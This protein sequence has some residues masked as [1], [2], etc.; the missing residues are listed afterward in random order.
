MSL[1]WQYIISFVICLRHTQVLIICRPRFMQLAETATF[2]SPKFY[3]LFPVPTLSPTCKIV[4][5]RSGR[6][7][8][9]LMRC[10]CSLCMCWS[11]NKPNQLEKVKLMNCRWYMV[12]ACGAIANLV[13]YLTV[14]LQSESNADKLW[15][16]QNFLIS[17]LFRLHF[18]SLFAPET[19]TS[20]ISCSTRVPASTPRTMPEGLRW[21]KPKITLP[22]ANSSTS[23]FVRTNASTT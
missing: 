17:L 8:N 1:W 20:S 21:M 7:F 18:T 4:V 22:Y 23:T 2:R 15:L 9:F 5:V 3:S 14:S 11:R 6:Q 16:G 19:T 12:Y 13:N 10:N